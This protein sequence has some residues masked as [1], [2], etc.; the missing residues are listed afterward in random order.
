[1]TQS[2]AY[3]TKTYPAVG[4]VRG[5]SGDSP[6]TIARL[7]EAQ[8]R[9]AALEA[10]LVSEATRP[11]EGAAGLASGDEDLNFDRGIQIEI[12]NLN[13]ESTIS[14]RQAFQSEFGI[15]WNAIL[16]A[17]GPAALDEAPQ[18]QLQE[19][20]MAAARRSASLEAR[21][22]VDDWL[23]K[24]TKASDYEGYQQGRAR[25]KPR[26]R[27]TLNPAVEAFD[28]ALIQ[29][30]ALGLM[31]P[32]VKKRGVNDHRVYWALTPWGRTRLTQLRSVKSG[33]TRPRSSRRQRTAR[34]DARLEACHRNT[35]ADAEIRDSML[36]IGVLGAR[37]S[38]P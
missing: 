31:T 17:L 34:A 28:T 12:L 14:R 4:W 9:I 37:M 7:A 24:G 25:P 38:T 33:S 10:Q 13:R 11:P 26:Y 15:S 27:L 8:D 22:E 30:Q 32:G 5:D 35:L 29:M 16:S 20:F 6:K 21:S 1:V 36:V 3:F 2:F 18:T 23:A 19:R